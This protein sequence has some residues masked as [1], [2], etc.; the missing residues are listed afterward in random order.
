MVLI[1]VLTPILLIGAVLFY[2]YK[3]QDALIQKEITSLNKQFEGEITIGD[4]HFSP[5]EHF[6]YIS[7]KIDEVHVY[8]NKN[9]DSD[10]ILNV[11][12]IYIGFDFDDIIQGKFDIQNLAIE[13]GFFNIIFHEDGTT[14]L[15]KA[16]ATSEDTATSPP[17]EIHLKKIKLRNLDV[18]K[19]DEAS[20]IDIETYIYDAKGGFQSNDAI[21]SAHIDTEFELNVID[22]GDTTFVRHKHFEFHTDVEFNK[23]NGLLNI[24]PSG[25]K[26]EH[27]SFDLEGTVDT[28]NDM[29][30]DL[31][32][33][34]A[35]PNFDMFVAFVPTELISTLQHYKN[36][37]KIYF[38]AVVQGPT[39][40]GRKPLVDVNFGASE[41]FLENTTEQK[42]IENVGFQGHFTNGIER[43]IRSMEFSLT[44]MT[45]S[46]ET[47]MFT[48]SI[49]VKN[50]KEPEIDMSINS[51]FN[52][53]FLAQFLNITDI[54]NVKG[55]VALKMKFH[56]IIDLEHPERAL[57][58]LNQAYFTELKV[59]DISFSSP[60][61]PAKLKQL[62][63]HLIMNGKQATLDQFD[64]KMG[65]SDLSINGYVSDLPAIAHHT[66]K[67]VVTHFEISSTLLD[68]AEI[69]R[70]ST[71]DSTGFDEQITNLSLGLSFKSS[72]KEFTESKYLPK[73][74][75]YIDSLHAQLKHYPHE[76]HDF[77][78]DILI[79]EKDLKIK[80]F[81][82]YIDESDFHFNGSVHDYEFW[83][84]EPL[85]GDV[86]LDLTLTS[87]VLHLDNIF[88]Y[89]G[90]NY[91]PKDY[92]HEELDK[93]TLHVNA[94]MH[95]K[96]G[97]LHSLDM[98]LDKLDV[99]MHVHPMRFENFRG[100]F[101]YE[102][103]H[104][105]IQ[106]FH[107][108]MGR[109]IFD[110]NMNYYLG[111]DSVVK[112]R[113]NLL[114]LKANYIDFDQLSNFNLSGKKSN[115]ADT[116]VAV[117]T[118][119]DAALHAETFNLYELP[120]TDMQFEVDIGHFIYHRIDL[121]HINTH[122]RSTHNHYIHIDTLDM[123]AA[124][125]HFSL[126]GYFNGSDPKHIYFK[127]DL[128]IQNVDLD[129]LMFKFENFGQDH[130][131]SENIHG[132]L[133]TR[134]KGKV[135]MYPDMVPDLDQSEIH[136]DVEILNGKLENYDPLLM[137]SD[138]MGDKNL[139]S[140]RFDTLANHMDLTNGLLTIPSMTI[141]ST[142]G[143]MELSGSQDMEEN[144]E[145]YFRIPWKTVRKGAR[146]KLF[147]SKKD[148]KREA[149]EDE[150]IEV[151]PN[152]KVKYLNLRIK[153]DKDGYK[154]RMKKAKKSK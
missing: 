71:T 58:K 134:I 106:K 57:E 144:M 54:K 12:D 48:G 68:L 121:Q 76:L 44:E 1:V 94:S 80:D 79:D 140:V 145:Y 85:N 88:S 126:S 19:Y 130:M 89:Q 51:D 52:I 133:S 117:H 23:K 59:K 150:I 107:G 21:V 124:G 138:Y 120:F 63:M 95:Y 2:V 28:K 11:A 3:N 27:G 69:T 101:H 15:E 24:Q 87:N 62:D 29:T 137:L 66:N 123:D 72:A 81:I 105:V 42:R 111:T 40:M 60:S 148:K 129:K 55:N 33:K 78:V 110:V 132:K 4:T 50:F 75:F 6:P 73:G 18:H 127:P 93:L 26:L 115:P 136:M 36:A 119:K 17:L 47:G 5:F 74:E 97:G 128:S 84:K 109:T 141:E 16:F 14:N 20:E 91:V 139:K 49:V 154:I 92:Q 9:R 10:T 65:N 41:A 108:K 31:A 37:G 61:L 122:I 56:D 147:G 131:L 8:E 35:K 149:T 118:K 135:R 7:I 125:G 153:G 45:A 13:D 142:L 103:E 46:L 99:K 114:S 83:M 22:K 32:I 86:D 104:L 70:F 100:R 90:I 39:S 146:N 102:D 34:G 25:I 38:N 98:D 30:L 77:H 113:D 43:D 152:K 53:G 64:M 143:H 112:K 82:G 96:N 67:T 151:D 116:V